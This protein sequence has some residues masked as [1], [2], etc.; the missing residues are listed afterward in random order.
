MHPIERLR[1]VA[2]ASGADQGLLVRETAGALSGLG[3]DPAGLVT[4]CRRIIDRHV[5][6]GPLWWLCSKVL[7]AEDP[8]RAAW[9]AV[10]QI[11]TDATAE[12]L[13]YALPDG[14]TVC[15]LGWPE[16]IGDALLRRGDVDVL[17]VD[18]LGEGTGLARRLRRSDVDAI[19]VPMAGLGAAAAASDLVLLEPSAGGAGGVIAMAGSHAAAAVGAHGQVPGWLV[20][21]VGRL[22]PAPVWNAL[23]RRLDEDT[24]PWDRDDVVVPVDLLTGV[25]G[26]TGVCSV[27]EAVAASDCPVAP[28]LFRTTAF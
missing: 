17:V 16:T 9:E 3:F 15:V 6:S 25:V 24:D 11:E 4:A 19:E 13:A 14:S 21:G 5:V 2:R 27:D 8:M 23:R 26:T 20:A 10:D 18:A 28:E 22:L 1:Y 7:T 12:E